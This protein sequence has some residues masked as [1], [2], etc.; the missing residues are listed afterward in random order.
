[1]RDS[2]L[3]QAPSLGFCSKKPARDRKWKTAR[4]QSFQRGQR[5]ERELVH[6][7]SLISVSISISTAGRLATAI[8]SAK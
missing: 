6:F 8:H 2:K 3:A 1:M 7:A 5:C 4:A